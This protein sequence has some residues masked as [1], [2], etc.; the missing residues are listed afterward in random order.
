MQISPIQINS[1]GKLNLNDI[2]KALQAKSYINEIS[3]PHADLDC[4][5]ATNKNESLKDYQ[6]E[7]LKGQILCD[8]GTTIFNRTTTYLFRSD[9]DWDNFLEYLREKYKDDDK[10]NTYVYACSKGY[11]AYSLSILLQEISNCADTKFFPIHAKDI[12]N[13]VKHRQGSNWYMN[14]GDYL[15]LDEH[16]FL[17]PRNYPKDPRLKYFEEE[18]GVFSSPTYKLKDNV[19]NSIEFQKANILDDIENIDSQNPSIL[20]A[21]NMWP[22]VNPREY[23]GF[24]KNLY[25]K[26]A[27]NSIV[28]I[29]YF[30]ID[31]EKIDGFYKLKNSDKFPQTLIDAGFKPSNCQ[32]GFH[33]GA[34]D[35]IF[36]KN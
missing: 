24:A 30:D 23:T 11:E 4:H 2:R 25:K 29:G 26:L 33:E 32:I 28:V 20:M 31:G 6:K 9:M 27:P 19:I 34:K 16:S 10:V 18:K 14:S 36:E 22:Y 17:N 13:I 21:R 35:L 3:T 1:S 15:R 8:D 5:L 7:I 12:N